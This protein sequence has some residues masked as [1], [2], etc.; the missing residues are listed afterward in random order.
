MSKRN[1]NLIQQIAAWDN[2]VDA[3]RK[4]SNGKRRTWGYL[5]FKEYDLANLL[6]GRRRYRAASR[7]RRWAR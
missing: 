6:G 2:L 3:Y 5:E 1:R 4:T 7:P